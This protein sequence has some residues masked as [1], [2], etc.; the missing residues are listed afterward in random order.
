MA[1]FTS[2]YPKG[3]ARRMTPARVVYVLCALACAA[4]ALVLAWYYPLGATAAGVAMVGLGGV[5]F[6]QPRLWLVL[7]PALS[8]LI[9]W[10]PWSGW[11]TFEEVDMLVLAAAAAGYARLAFQP[12]GAV[13]P[14]SVA[15]GATFYRA[16]VGLVTV[17]FAASVAWSVERGFADAGGFV[18]GWFQGYHEPMNSV[19]LAK[20]FF[21]A[22]LLWPLWGQ[23]QQQA[24]ERANKALR[25]G[26]ALGLAGVAIFTM[27]ERTAFVGLMNFSAD[28]RT[29]ALFWEMHVGGAALDGFLALAIPFAVIALVRAN[30]AQQGVLAGGVLVLAGY[31]WLTTF[32][33]G[34]Y[35]AVPMGLIT[36]VALLARQQR[37]DAGAPG[38]HL[39]RGAALVVA[40]GACTAWLFGSSGYRGMLA[41]LGCMVL[42]LP[43]AGMVRQLPARQ[44][45]TGVVLG[46]A[47]AVLA[48][49]VALFQPRGVYVVYALT[50]V[51]SAGM[52]FLFARFQ[53]SG[54]RMVFGELALAGLVCA[55]ATMALVA[56]HWGE[57]R[58]L[59]DAMPAVLMLVVLLGGMMVLRQR[60]QPVLPAG[61]KWQGTVLG[62]MAMVGAMVG[63]FGGGAYM[64]DRFATGRQDLDGRFAHWQQSLAGLRTS[65]DWLLGRGMGRFPDSQILGDQAQGHPGDYRL[66]GQGNEAYLAL[67]SGKQQAMGYEEVFRVSQRVAVPTI[68]LR[69]EAKVRTG[70]AASL[71]FEVCEK[72]LLYKGN[73]LAQEMPVKAAPGQWQSVQALVKDGALSR[74]D[75]YAPRQ[76]VFS[77]ALRSAQS[78]VQLDDLLVVGPNGVNLL[79]NGD[80]N[81]GMAR[82]F[83]S[84]DRSH[85]PWH[86]KNIFLNVLFDQGYVG[87]GMWLV[88]LLAGLFNVMFGVGKDHPLAPA[89]A[90][91]LVGFVVVGLFDSL[92][93][94]PRVAMLFYF[95]LFVGL[96]LRPARGRLGQPFAATV[97]SPRIIASEVHRPASQAVD[98]P[99]RPLFVGGK[100]PMRTA[101][102]LALVGA[103]AYVVWPEGRSLSNTARGTPG[104][105]LRYVKERLREHDVLETVLLPPINK[106]QTY[107]ERPP[108]DE[109]L[110]TL[111]KGQQAQSLPPQQFDAV[112]RPVPYALLAQVAAANVASPTSILA[113]RAPADLKRALET[114]Q[115]GQVIEL[116]AGT[117]AINF[118]MTTAGVGTAREPI[119]LRAKKPGDVVLQLATVEGFHVVQP[120][121]VFENLTIRGVCPSDTDC[122]HAFHVTGAAR[123]VVIR[124]NH[125]ENFNAHIKVNGEGGLWPDDGL[126]QFNTLTN[127]APRKTKNPVTLFDLVA[128]NN[129]LVADNVVSDFVKDGSNRIS[130]GMFMKGAGMGGRF[131]RNLIICT[132][133]G[134]SQPGSRVGL[135]WGGGTTG[136][137]F[138]RD[139]KCASEFI[140]GVAAN[141]VVAHCNDAGIDV[142]KGQ[143]ISLVNNTLINTQGINIRGESTEVKM[144]GNLLEGRV[145]FGPGRSGS[146]SNNDVLTLDKVLQDPD[147]L[148]LTRKSATPA[149]VPTVPLAPA[150]FFNKPRG[151]LT[152]TGAV[153]GR[154]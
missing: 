25:L 17:S 118:A 152:W 114:A 136:P 13:A 97:E 149:D 60:P 70:A 106:L 126:L 154:N 119:T 148:T 35:L 82:W 147:R 95:V 66:V 53:T 47:A 87:L 111:G 14:A 16:L 110:P 138:C 130:Y 28:Y 116:A 11:V 6:W 78:V 55:V 153:D 27:W 146:E 104:E 22:L 44:I 65:A 21:F 36:L 134:I 34:V 96:S 63:V 2:S 3:E 80:F 48:T 93:D 71:L 84:S 30:N 132:S 5:M 83:S 91:S 15:Q 61:Y 85:L 121:W 19:R 4:L 103:L 41:L 92:L 125:I 144:V 49:L 143:Q 68:P 72:H 39:L 151:I 81:D 40:F 140:Q 42:I 67:S 7:V 139:G 79:T 32:S 123:G 12:N 59:I 29:T 141:N 124:N 62:S 76:V 117:Y 102:T 88:L 8:P 57:Q 69:M 86:L 99:A 24:P 108:P 135:S 45:V 122:E 142:N 129:W 145:R 23:A 75:W 133:K 20:A 113:V 64:G 127:P 120:Y 77:V 37:S 38:L 112:G 73:C 46:A 43:M 56:L 74:G 105:M 109:Q 31:A 1:T 90:A 94:V 18:F 107:I 54:K 26:V 115:P 52:L 150:D 128:A 101:A 33:R 131:E 89:V 58:G 50:V 10:A 51:F 100:T 98:N 137:R 9:G